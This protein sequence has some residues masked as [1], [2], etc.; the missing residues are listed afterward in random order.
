MRAELQLQHRLPPAL[1]IKRKAIR[2][3]GWLFGIKHLRFGALLLFVLR[4]RVFGIIF[5]VFLGFTLKDDS[6]L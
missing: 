5:L 1:Q 3:D 6:G 2:R 4:L